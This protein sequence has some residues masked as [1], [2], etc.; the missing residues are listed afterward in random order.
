MLFK[1]G[2]R[3]AAIIMA[4]VLMI[5]TAN[6]VPE[7]TKASDM[8]NVGTPTDAIETVVEETTTEIT[9]E[10]TTENVIAESDITTEV[11]TTERVIEE[12]E[13]ITTEPGTT[14]N[15]DV[16][17]TD[18]TTEAVTTEAVEENATKT[19]AEEEKLTSQ[20]MFMANGMPL[21]RATGVTVSDKVTHYC[22]GNELSKFTFSNGQVAICMEFSKTSAA[23]NSAIES[24][25]VYTTDNTSMAYKVMYYGYNGPEQWSG[26]GNE[27]NA[28]VGTGVLLS[29]LTNGSPD[30]ALNSTTVSNF[31]SYIQSAPTPPKAQMSFSP[32]SVSTSVSDGVQKSN[33][34]TFSADSRL[35]VT[36][37]LDSDMTLYFDGSTTP[38]TGNVTIKG[39][40]K[41]Y[42][43]APLTR[44]TDFSQNVSY[45]GGKLINVMQAVP[46]YASSGVQKMAYSTKQSI[47]ANLAIDFEEEV[48]GSIKIHKK[49]SNPEMA[50]TIPC[51]N[52]LTATFGV[53]SSNADA[54]AEQNAVKTFTTNSDGEGS[55]TDLPLDT[56]YVKELVAPKNYEKS[57]TVYIA[58]VNSPSVPVEFDVVNYLYLDPLRIVVKKEDPEGRKLQGAEFEIKYYGLQQDTPNPVDPA[59]LGYS[60]IRTWV[61]RSD[62]YG[63]AQF[64][65][66]HKVSGDAF[67]YNNFNEPSIPIGTITIQETKAPEGY[68][69]DPTIRVQSVKNNA[70]LEDEHYYQTS[71]IPNTEFKAYIKVIKVDKDSQKPILNNNAKF[72]IWSY[73]DNAYVSFNVN[74]ANVSEFSTDN[75]GVL[76]TPGTLTCGNYR[77]DEIECPEG[78][79]SETA[80]GVDLTISTTANYE[81]HYDANG[82]VITDMGTFVVTRDNTSTKG[83]IE[84]NKRAE[85]ITWDKESGKY[86]STY[87]P[88]AGVVFDVFANTDIYSP[89]G[90]NTIVY[91]KGERVAQITTDTNGYAKTG[92][93]YLGEFRVV[94]HIP[95]GY[96]SVKDQIVILSLD[97]QKNDINQG[98]ITKKLVYETVDLNNVMQRAKIKVYKTDETSTVYL[99][100]A[101][102]E[103]YEYDA[104][105]TTSEDYISNG[106]KVSEGVTDKNGE[107]EFEGYFPLGDYAIIEAKAPVGYEADVTAHII[108]AEYDD[109]AVEYIL[110]ED[111]FIDTSIKGYIEIN[112]EAEKLTWDKESGK[113]VSTYEPKA[114]VKFDIFADEDIYTSFGE[115]NL[116]YKSGE[117]VDTITTD[118]NGY[119][120]SIELYLG[121]YKVKESVPDGYITV[122]DETVTLSLDSQLKEITDDEGRVKKLMYE[123]LVLKNLMQQAQIKVYKT[124]KDKI[125]YLEGAEYN[126]YEY[127]EA[128]TTVDDY[129]DKG[130]LVSSGVTDSNGEL[131]FNGYFPL[132][133]YAAIETKAPRGYITDNL[134]HVIKAEYDDSGIEYIYVGDSYINDSIKGSI[135]LTKRDMEDKDKTLEGVKFNLYKVVNDESVM[136]SEEA[137]YINGY[138]GMSVDEQ[139]KINSFKLNT[140]DMFIGEFVTDENGEIHIDNLLYGEYY[141]IETETLYRYNINETPQSFVIDENE[142]VY[143]MDVYNDGRVG[144]LSIWG[145]DGPGEGGGHHKTGDNAPIMMAIILAALS[146][147]GIIF[148][149]KRK[150]YAGK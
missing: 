111:T 139:T 7:S 66:S 117:L 34:I 124:D 133:D 41:F 150:K 138:K 71:T 59:T 47:S 100:G 98:G 60:P 35:S 105:L 146:L 92:E 96:V 83:Y 88:K 19:D 122:E 142:V 9:T 94:E 39:G 14:E 20:L 11:I 74:G 24:F 123:T 65:D 135:N 84:L 86:V 22:D 2:K 4:V 107:L 68:V 141:F 87:V 136:F 16:N 10:V 67:W 125:Y 51:Y 8:A 23:Y 36:L 62:E 12:T 137:D 28:I 76:I 49:P 101:E 110:V 38:N 145:Y 143:Q 79:Y 54:V 144:T 17:E 73:D 115:G 53:Y 31:Y 6:F 5:T 149:L 85:V 33:L 50:N 126:L 113:Y 43:T 52:D 132:G 118:E 69:I 93:L 99:E 104:A 25:N 116:V 120:K 106:V 45:S 147:T 129:M 30:Y 127:N 64:R 29:Y 61:I 44:S 21:N 26:F 78:Y 56:Y 89:D 91:Q 112:K 140:E 95:D 75:S 121:K 46:A 1:R 81:K 119:A 27:S 103:L 134:V 82:N 40:Q 58:E 77:I 63:D 37:Q 42:I 55:V 130:V 18:A 57:N 148:I 90:Q 102:F 48:K 15:V 72:K 32:S 3:I 109:T 128:F 108:K 70:D 97:S 80:A 131:V 114:D 13:A